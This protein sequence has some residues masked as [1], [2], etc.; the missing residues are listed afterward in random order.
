MTK[1]S[2]DLTANLRVEEL[3]EK[4]RDKLLSIF[5]YPKGNASFK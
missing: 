1:K 5:I 4:F 2:C 3:G